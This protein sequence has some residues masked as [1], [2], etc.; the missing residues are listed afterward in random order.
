LQPGAFRVDGAAE[1][2]L[3]ETGFAERV[4][5]TAT[6]LPPAVPEIHQSRENAQGQYLAEANL[7]LEPDL[8]FGEP[9]D[10]P[11]VMRRRA[12]FVFLL[13]IGLAVGVG[14]GVGVGVQGGG[15]TSA[16]PIFDCS[17]VTVGCRYTGTQ[18][19]DFQDPDSFLVANCTDTNFE[20][21]TND[22]CECEVNI[23][24]YSPEGFESCQSCSFVNSDE[25]EWRL[26]YDCS[27]LLRGECVGRATSNNCISRLRFNTTS[28]LRRAVDDYLADNSTDSVVARN[29]GSP[30]GIWDVSQIEDF[31]YLF[32]GDE[33]AFSEHFNSAAANFNENISGW[34]MA[35]ATTV[36]SMF[37]GARSFDQPIGSW[38]V[39]SVRDMS[40]MFSRATSFD[41]PIGDWNVSRVTDMSNTFY[42]ATSFNSPLGDWEV[43]SV[44]DMTY[45]FAHANS[46]NS[47]S[48]ADW[49]ISNETD[50]RGI[51]PGA[52]GIVQAQVKVTH[53]TYPQE[54]GWT[55]RDSSGTLIARQSTCSF[56]NPGRTFTKTSSVALGTY[57]FEMTDTRGNGI[58]CENGPGSFSIAVNGETV[59]SK[60]GQFIDITQETF[61]VL[62]PTPSR[63]LVFETR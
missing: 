24:T 62:A 27:N 20:I 63:L 44:R 55:L 22:N 42:S 7:V 19:L 3:S 32:S 60:N 33:S 29:Y 10:E 52:D 14:V 30:I 1:R 35:S 48:I 25:G 16:T 61:E 53:D 34:N 15:S 57:T 43:S 2:T 36:T 18:L 8:V 37:A 38:N 28:E 26:A 56:N 31:S 17:N 40:F 54:T 39:S 58:C 49:D 59:I 6:A 11:E 46:F 4:A 47:Q 21:P 45:M 50:M 41:Q 51:F 9:L 23:P 13:V 12:F 5:A